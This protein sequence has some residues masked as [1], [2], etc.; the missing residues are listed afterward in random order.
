MTDF[1]KK[2]KT[3][4]LNETRKKLRFRSWHRGTKE[5]DVLL[6]R[7]A[8]EYVMDFDETELGQYDRLLK[9]SDPDLYNWVSGNEPLP[10]SE[11]SAVMQMFM[12]FKLTE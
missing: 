6:G 12:N 4:P 3:D 7:F 1:S 8:D 5:M 10:P 11:D 2:N 9:N